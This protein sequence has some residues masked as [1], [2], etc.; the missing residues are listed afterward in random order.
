M[1]KQHTVTCGLIPNIFP[2]PCVPGGIL[3]RSGAREALGHF[4]P[5]KGFFGE[6]PLGL[7]VP[8]GAGHFKMVEAAPRQALGGSEG[9][10]GRDSRGPSFGFPRGFDQNEGAAQSAARSPETPSETPPTR[11]F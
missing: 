11:P 7:E 4:A 3:E 10:G 5:Q 9:F 8:T 2:L 6:P 1:K